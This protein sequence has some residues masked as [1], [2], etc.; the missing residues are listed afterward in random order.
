MESN[1]AKKKNRSDKQT[2]TEKIMLVMTIIMH[3]SVVTV[4]GRFTALQYS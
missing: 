3:E 1:K 2:R 4:Q